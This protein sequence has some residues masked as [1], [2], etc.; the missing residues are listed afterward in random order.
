[1]TLLVEPGDVEA[2]TR[3][4]K[5]TTVEGLRQLQAAGLGWRSL[6]RS[7]SG[8]GA[9]LLASAMLCRGDWTG[10]SVRHEGPGPTAGLTKAADAIEAQAAPD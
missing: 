10:R 7:A 5:T 4:M 1:M 3:V 6:P 9:F 2:L 8:I